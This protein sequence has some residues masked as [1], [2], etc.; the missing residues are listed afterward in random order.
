MEDV[1]EHGWLELNQ[2]TRNLIQT[3]VSDL[4][5]TRVLIHLG[6]KFVVCI[7]KAIVQSLPVYKFPQMELRFLPL[8]TRLSTDSVKTDGRFI[9]AVSGAGVHKSLQ[10][11]V[12][13]RVALG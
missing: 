11:I 10:A 7:N 12:E 5:Y 6:N 9:K 2:G 4:F 1:V 13:G 3:S 8:N